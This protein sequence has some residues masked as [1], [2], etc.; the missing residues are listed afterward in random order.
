MKEEGLRFNEG[1]L[2]FDLTHPVANEG[3]ARVLTIGANKYAERNWEKGMKWSKVVASLKRHLHAFE[4]GE[5]FDKESGELHVNH[6]LC[7]AHFLSAYYKIAP[8]FDDRLHVITQK[9]KI[10]LDVDEVIAD[11]LNPWTKKF[12][13]EVPT[14]WFFD[15]NIVDRFEELR[16]KGELDEFYLNL[17][18]L[19]KPEDIPFEPH[20]YVTSRPVDTEVTMK[21]LEK[22]GFPLRPV[23]TVPPGT[24]KLE[25]I[26]ESGTDIFVDDRYDTFE[27]LNRNGI[28]CFLFDQPHNR[29]YD[30]GYK[31]I[32]SLRQL[33]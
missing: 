12:N 22:H 16:Q 27:E 5:D 18:P 21:W 33:V 26:K 2:R 4:S 32:Y 11:W 9:P 28:C 1:K 20:C 23:K 10:S 17:Q 25:I 14:T 3:L 15:Y 7:N 24:S 19:I 8:Q 30:V 29:R 31:R 6:I 13:L